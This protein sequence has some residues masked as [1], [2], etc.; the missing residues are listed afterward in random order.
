MNS[1]ISKSFF[2]SNKTTM[3]LI[4]LLPLAFFLSGCGEANKKSKILMIEVVKSGDEKGE[5]ELKFSKESIEKALK[6]GGQIKL[7]TDDLKESYPEWEL[8]GAT[9]TDGRHYIRGTMVNFISSLGWHFHSIQWGT[10][11]FT[12]TD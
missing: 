3:V 6:N 8:Y 11:V 10:I 7:S 2:K 4:L 9:S 5:D 1:K 12:K